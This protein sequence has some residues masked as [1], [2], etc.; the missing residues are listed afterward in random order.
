METHTGGK[1]IRFQIDYNSGASTTQPGGTPTATPTGTA[2]ASPTAEPA[3]TETPVPSETPEPTQPPAAPTDTPPAAEP[4]IAPTPTETPAPA[5][6]PTLTPTETP[7]LTPTP[8]RTPTRTPIPPS[9]LTITAVYNAT[10]DGLIAFNYS[11][12]LGNFTLHPFSGHPDSHSSGSIAAGT[13]T[14]TQTV[15]PTSISCFSNLGGASFPVD[16]AHGKVTVNLRVGE[17]VVC[18]FDN[19]PPPP[20]TPV[21]TVGLF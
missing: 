16:L 18:T 1:D 7:T 4:T 17:I 5:N 15:A 9:T 11:G 6:T 14:V 3:A 12:S 21:P 2:T 20:P 8:T 13:Y 10:S 19:T